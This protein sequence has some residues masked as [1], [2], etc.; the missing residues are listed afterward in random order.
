MPL[1]P[2]PVCGAGRTNGL[3]PLCLLKLAMEFHSLGTARPAGA[4]AE[5]TQGSDAG[6][7]APRSEATGALTPAPT[8]E[9]GDHDPKAGR[10]DSTLIAADGSDRLPR[11]TAVR[12][13]GDCEIRK[14]LGRGGMGVVY[15]A[16]QISLNRSVAIKMIKAGVLA[17]AAELQRFQNEAEA[18]AP[19]DRAGIVPV[20]EVGEHDG[21]R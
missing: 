18:V 7:H 1:D 14:E 17:D 5:A 10:D 8:G 13:F 3:C 15:Q 9:T 20:Y 2:C 4:D 6:P 21:Q 11:G 12:Y 16:L 19:L